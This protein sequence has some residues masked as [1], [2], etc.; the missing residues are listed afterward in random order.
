MTE[1]WDWAWEG[2]IGEADNGNPAPLL[3]RLR[4]DTP[5][6]MQA[7][8]MLADL[9]ESGRLRTPSPLKKSDVHLLLA[10][11]EF[12]E[13]R[14]LQRK[15]RAAEKDSAKASKRR[16]AP[17][18]TPARYRGGVWAHYLAEAGC[19]FVRGGI[20]SPPQDLQDWSRDDLVRDVAQFWS[21]P[22]KNLHSFLEGEGGTYRRLR[23][24]RAYSRALARP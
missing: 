17:R 24:T 2:A 10:A 8:E 23:K 11:R 9:L 3:S 7:R 1:A 18:D 16:R 22:E 13:L 20:Y 14:L 15:I 12:H 21:V 5:L 19:F 4:G 6:P